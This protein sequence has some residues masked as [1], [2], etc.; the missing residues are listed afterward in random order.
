LKV[1]VNDFLIYQNF[2]RFGRSGAY[3]NSPTRFWFCVSHEQKLQQKLTSP[4][5]EKIA[6]RLLTGTKP[7]YDENK[8]MQQKFL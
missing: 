4:N 7:T 8:K 1:F 6:K 3:K 5:Q 2:K